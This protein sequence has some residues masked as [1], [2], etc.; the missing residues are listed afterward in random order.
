[1]KLSCIF[2][3]LNESQGAALDVPFK[4]KGDGPGQQMDDVV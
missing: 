3:Y 2:S 1:M 4:R